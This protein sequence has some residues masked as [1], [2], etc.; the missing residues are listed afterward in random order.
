MK[1][2]DGQ[3]VIIV[4]NSDMAICVNVQKNTK[5]SDEQLIEMIKTKMKDDNIEIDVIKCSLVMSI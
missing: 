1:I 2:L 4:K 5:Y 3:K